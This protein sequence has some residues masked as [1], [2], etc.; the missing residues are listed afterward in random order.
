MNALVTTRA[1]DGIGLGF[2]IN[3]TRISLVHSVERFNQS[4]LACCLADL[5]SFAT[6]ATLL[7]P[8]WRALF[9]RSSGALVL[10]RLALLARVNRHGELHV[11]T[12]AR[13]EIDISDDKTSR[14]SVNIGTFTKLSDF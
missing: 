12:L 2:Q 10:Q 3:N 8:P 7:A 5:E 6:R 1:N 13:K 9:P 4:L 14:H 11:S